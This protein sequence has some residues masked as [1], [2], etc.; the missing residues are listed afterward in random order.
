MQRQSSPVGG[1]ICRRRA[2]IADPAGALK[3]RK[4]RFHWVFRHGTALAELVRRTLVRVVRCCRS[5]VML[6]ALAAASAAIDALKSLTSS[7]SS[8][9]TTTG[10][11][12][13]ASNPFD[14]SGS[15]STQASTA[16]STGSSS[17]GSQISPQ[18]M[19]ALLDAQSQSSTGST[20][21]SSTTSASS[22]LKDLFSKIDSDGD[23]K[24]TKSEF[25]NALGAGGTNLKAADSV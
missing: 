22:A 11:T 6:P 4:A 15:S 21:A 7:K 13:A 19:S 12:Q 14:L 23:G 5:S 9:T 25:E 3:Q 1:K 18:T 24:I 20:P 10:F 2:P 16:T 8:S 17:G